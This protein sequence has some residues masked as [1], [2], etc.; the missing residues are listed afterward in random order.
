MKHCLHYFSLLLGG[1][2]LLTTGRLHAQC[3]PGNPC[4]DAQL[5][6][7]SGSVLANLPYSP[8]GANTSQRMRIRK[9]NLVARL[10]LEK[11]GV[12]PLVKQDW[13]ATLN[14]K[15]T[16]KR[17]NG[18]VLRVRDLA[19]KA[20]PGKPEVLGEVDVTDIEGLIGSVEVKLMGYTVSG[21]HAQLARQHVRCILAWAPE[22]GYDVQTPQNQALAVLDP[23]VFPIT[24]VQNASEVCQVRFAWEMPANQHV[25][26]FEVE[27]LKAEPKIQSG[28][29]VL[30]WTKANKLVLET[31]S[32]LLETVNGGTAN[33]K[34]Y[35]FIYLLAEGTGYYAWRVR[36]LGDY[37]ERGL[38]NA[39]NY[40]EWNLNASVIANHGYAWKPGGMDLQGVNP[41]NM[42]LLPNGNAVTGS[43]FYYQQFDAQ[44]NFI[45]GRIFSEGSRMAETMTYANGLSQAQQTQTRSY[46]QH[47][48]LGTQ[49]VLDFSGRPALQSMVAPMGTD[50]LQYRSDFFRKQGNLPYKAEDF[51]ANG[52]VYPGATIVDATKGPGFYYSDA[53]STNAYPLGDLVPDANGFPYTRTLFYPDATG[54]VY[55]QSAPGEV[56]RLKIGGH[57]VTT[58]YGAVTQGELDIVFGNEAPVD[59]TVYKVVSLDPNTVSS[60]TYMAKNGTVLATCLS[61]NGSLSN[62]EDVGN[63]NKPGI[64]TLHY[65]LSGGSRTVGDESVHQQTTIIVE[66]AGT[67]APFYYE[68]TPQVFGI[69]CADDI[70]YTCDYRVEFEIVLTQDPDLHARFYFDIPPVRLAQCQATQSAL[71]LGSNALPY[72]QI[73]FDPANTL[74]PQGLIDI[75]AGK[76][77]FPEAGTYL[78]TKTIYANNPTGVGNSR[79][80]DAYLDSLR[81]MREGWTADTNCCGPIVVDTS[82]WDCSATEPWCDST[83]AKRADSLMHW[84]ELEQRADYKLHLTNAGLNLTGNSYIGNNYMQVLLNYMIV[85]KGL[86]CSDVWGCFQVMGGQLEQNIAGFDANGPPLNTQSGGLPNTTGNPA[87]P[88]YDPD[89]DFMKEVIACTG[90]NDPCRQYTEVMLYRGSA[91]SN[92]P[93]NVLALSIPAAN[94]QGTTDEMHHL[95]CVMGY[96]TFNA[97]TITTPYTLHYPN[98]GLSDAAA[99][100]GICECVQTPLNSGGGSAV[101][102]DSIQAGIVNACETGCENHRGAFAQAIDNWVIDYN[103]AR[104]AVSM[105]DTHWVNIDSIMGLDRECVI[106][107]MVAQCKQQCQM[108]K[109]NSIDPDSMSQGPSFSQAY[110]DSILS[111]AFQA[112]L[113]QERLEFEQAMTWNAAF[114]PV[115]DPLGSGG[116]YAD[117]GSLDVVEDE[118]LSFLERAM[119]EVLAH[120]SADANVTAASNLGIYY[121][122]GSTAN[123]ALA[124]RY[125]DFVVPM[126]GGQQ[127]SFKQMTAVVGLY[128]DTATKRMKELDVVLFCNFAVDTTGSLDVLSGTPFAHW[129]YQ[130]ACGSC[131]GQVQQPTAAD[132]YLNHHPEAIGSCLR[133]DPFTLAVGLRSSEIVQ[134]RFD[135]QGVLHAALAGTACPAVVDADGICPSASKA[136]FSL[137][138]AAGGAANQALRLEIQSQQDYYDLF[139][140]PVTWQGDAIATASAIVAAINGSPSLPPFKAS[141]EDGTGAATAMV[142]IEVRPSYTGEV[143]ALRLGAMGTLGVQVNAL[144][145][146]CGGALDSLLKPTSCREVPNTNGRECPY[147][148]FKVD[149]QAS[150]YP[151]TSQG[152]NH[153][154]L[155]MIAWVDDAATSIIRTRLPER[156][157]YSPQ[158]GFQLYADYDTLDFQIG[159]AEFRCLV[160]F[161]YKDTQ[162]GEC[163]TDGGTTWHPCDTITS[164]PN[165]LYRKVVSYGNIHYFWFRVLKCPERSAQELVALNLSRLT[166]NQSLWPN[167][168]N[169]GNLPQGF[170]A[171]DDL[172]DLV[173]EPNGR[174]K[175]TS[176]NDNSPSY[177][178]HGLTHDLQLN[179]LFVSSGGVFRDNVTQVATS[180]NPC[181]PR[182]EECE[183]CMR[184]SK[185][186]MPDAFSDPVDYDP[187]TCE[188]ALQEYI[189][190]TVAGILDSCLTARLEEMK[191]RYYA[192][193]L[194]RIVDKCTIDID[195]TYHHY[196]LYYRDRANNLVATVPPEGVDFLNLASLNYNVTNPPVYPNHLLQTTYKYNSIQQVVEQNS[197]D[198]GTSR[199]WYNAAG[200]LVLSQDAQ[201]ALEGKHA[202]S[203]YDHLGRIVES[204]VLIGFVPTFAPNQP[205]IITE[206]WD[207]PS[208][209]NNL[210]LL[211]RQEVVHTQYTLPDPSITYLGQPQTHTRNRITHVWK[212]ENNT[213][214]VH[215]STWYSYDEHGSVRW[216]IQE[217][218]SLGRKQMRY[219][220]DLVSGNVNKVYYQEG[221]VEQFIHRYEYDADNRIVAVF[222]STDDK[223]W[224]RDAK[225]E[226][227]LHGPLA[228]KELGEDLV[229]GMDYV[230]TIEGYLKS[231]NQ[232]ELD[233]LKDPGR[234]GVMQYGTVKDE[235]AMELGYYAGDYGRTGSHI[236]Q[237]NAAV[238][239]YNGAGGMTPAVNDLYNG[240]ISYWMSN[241]R[242]G[243]VAATDINPVGLQMRTFRY[244]KLNRLRFANW[245][246]YENGTWQ[247]GDGT[248]NEAFTYDGNGNIKTLLRNGFVGT[249]STLDMDQLTYHYNYNPQGRLLD[250]RLYH[251]RDAVANSP[252]TDDLEDQ[253]APNTTNFTTSNNYRYDAEG[254]L[255]ADLSEGIQQIK[256][257]AAN[258]VREV[259]KTN[260]EHIY[261]VYDALGNRII[262]THVHE[263]S[264][265]PK[266][267]LEST[268]YVRDASGNPMG[269]YSLAYK[270]LVDSSYWKL[271]E[272]PIY[273]SERIGEYKP[274]LVLAA[275]KGFLGDF[276]E[277]TDV[278][279]DLMRMWLLP[280]NPNVVEMNLAADGTLGFV[281]LANSQGAMPKA[282]SAVQ[283]G[284]NGA[285]LFGAMVTDE[286]QPQLLLIGKDKNPMAGVGNITIVCGKGINMEPVIIPVPGV[287]D[288]YY[289]VYHAG[290]GFT[291]IKALEVDMAGNGGNGIVV[292][293]AGPIAMG[294]TFGHKLLPFTYTDGNS[295]LL[296]NSKSADGKSLLLQRIDVTAAG[297]SAPTLLA[298]V[299]MPYGNLVSA[300]NDLGLAADGKWLAL[301]LHMGPAPL[302]VTGTAFL[303]VMIW[304][305]DAASLLLDHPKTY[306]MQTGKVRRVEFSPSGDYLF[307]VK[308]VMGS[309]RLERLRL[310]DGAA[311]LAG[312]GNVNMNIQRITNGKMV[313]HYGLGTVLRRM[314]DPETNGTTFSGTLFVPSA[315][316]KTGE[317]P[318]AVYPVD[319]PMQDVAYRVK[320]ADH[321][322]IASTSGAPNA[323]GMNTLLIPT[324]GSPVATNPIAANAGLSRCIS[325]G[326]DAHDS[327]DFRHVAP[328]GWTNLN[329]VFRP[330]LTLMQNGMGL[331]G[332]PDLPS[333]AVELPGGEKG[334]YVFT[335]AVG[336]LKVHRVALSNGELAVV[337][338]NQNV[339]L[340]AGG[341][342]Q[343]DVANP[344][345]A[346]AGYNDHATG[347][348]SFLFVATKYNGAV[349]VYSFRLSPDRIGAGQFVKQYGNPNAANPGLL[350]GE[351]QVAPS[352]QELS[353]SMSVPGAGSQ[354]I[355][356]RLERFTVDPRLAAGL[357]YAGQVEVAAEAVGNGANWPMQQILSHDYSPEGKY[358]YFLQKGWAN[359]GCWIPTP[360]LWLKRVNLQTNAV[361]DITH[362]AYQEA[363]GT[364]RRG[365]DG[366]LYLNYQEKNPGNNYVP[367]LYGYGQLDHVAP[368]VVKASRS[369]VNLLGG[370]NRYGLPLQ[371]WRRYGEVAPAAAYAEREVGARVYELNDHLGNVR[372]TVGDEREHLVLGNG[373]IGFAKAGVLSFEDYFAF[374][375]QLPGRN[376]YIV[377][378]RFGFNGQESDDEVSGIRESYTFSFR[379]YDP[380]TMRFKSIDPLFQKYPWNSP[381][382]FAE[383]SPIRYI[384]FEGLEKADPKE[385][386]LAET[387]IECN[388]SNGGQSSY[389]PDITRE[390]F[391]NQLKNLVCNPESADLT[392]WFCGP[393]AITYTFLNYNP[394]AFTTAA[395]ELYDHGE[396]NIPGGGKITAV[397]HGNMSGSN[398]NAAF[399]LVAASLRA[400]QSGG[401]LDP[402]TPGATTPLAFRK[403]AN[404][405]GLRVERGG[406]WLPKNIKTMNNAAN[407]GKFSILLENYRVSHGAKY[408]GIFTYIG[409][410]YITMTT[411][412]SVHGKNLDFRWWDHRSSHKNDPL[413]KYE[414]TEV[415]FRQGVK[416]W[417]ILAK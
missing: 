36:P 19:L 22:I 244:D 267:T 194:D 41:G 226:Y 87:G 69:A 251:L 215:N 318:Q 210:P 296:V 89:F 81:V 80:L 367:Y 103:A 220:Y 189:E 242:S 21:V 127:P 124:Y 347:G 369:Q 415:N 386:E 94:G 294:S 169:P 134:F 269:I 146:G 118:L 290:A 186:R 63:E 44:K 380:R 316:I 196:T 60:V 70:C 23:L 277:A 245:R 331:Q 343:Y 231:I 62:L 112:L 222:T 211:Q 175:F 100:A 248:Y 302:Q 162:R 148:Y 257:N 376:S 88:Q 46:S 216:L 191:A 199:F 280:G 161:G 295:R 328:S 115:K 397:Q 241:I 382:A 312:S 409:V 410:H 84:V 37:H 26:A 34:R 14:L 355:H 193:C 289:V 101:N 159:D 51:D 404:S 333:I 253:G 379:E 105:A 282:H 55:K 322:W 195:V 270:P 372:V 77:K 160:G 209:P 261:F 335:F 416:G 39:L 307:V 396:V 27:L 12:Y 313:Y 400:S 348:G 106:D 11:N 176:Q 351:M 398:P 324:V 49:S 113:A 417:W 92:V 228:R 321:N 152:I 299:P 149:P 144:P 258:K 350:L 5:S 301:G 25:P 67:Q 342:L 317:F 385:F 306:S 153:A 166:A 65:S 181:G 405:L 378:N 223:I 93:P 141:N 368:V 24:C 225:Y 218:P 401:T 122:G 259:V 172:F 263:P 236:G 276:T 327:L 201:Q 234:D 271:D 413:N 97:Q 131:Q 323:S 391:G 373:Q 278:A 311:L 297:F 4:L 198:G 119:D 99:A 326:E 303:D 352:G 85:T 114:A 357:A 117:F 143:M 79:W 203:R 304:G 411:S 407:E 136:T 95:A 30:D 20:V 121:R 287:A 59:T 365:A 151:A 83:L 384:E 38:S 73:Q 177:G 116:G 57:N 300:E 358:V 207:E 356:H 182:K 86:N 363:K 341:F 354:P 47:Q 17:G 174:L 394:I 370:L 154:I 61:H 252:Y 288:H 240:N 213:G 266:Q 50:Q 309:A 170:S 91:P 402:D 111:P 212:D 325:I 2:L 138:V 155:D 353:I 246:K 393:T 232:V 339:G 171:I 163:S 68:I 340:A 298:V 237:A 132:L 109:T 197:P 329:L 361:Q 52:T 72:T 40:G 178:S 310:A 319:G 334:Y 359:P 383:N 408:G 224:E 274:D 8:I 145:Q 98:W 66:Q 362:Y 330:D 375:A 255:V 125:Q 349:S 185:A 247:V 135:D 204:G 102:M 13:A 56:M 320:T 406:F 227:Y 7:T 110:A 129:S 9:L 221:T 142:T 1:L 3:P 336:R 128:Y 35:Q 188:D 64:Q 173:L 71:V 184:W 90:M 332:E 164:N 18:T 239:P 28:A 283:T 235:F 123:L 233:S 279:P 214:D 219:D 305:I 76:L 140:P 286:A 346:I 190:N 381:Y 126:G 187:Y 256:W 275:D 48:V 388:I 315:G 192:A 96:Y 264:Q 345:V 392:E 156:T 208:F 42:R 238:Y 412:I 366:R 139:A 104:G 371:A 249:G 308:E 33:R 43:I 229:Q 230:Y 147:G 108:E 338:S 262:K 395:F 82:G 6:V 390:E 291:A 360:A 243:Q 403:M 157:F 165:I 268:F 167:F 180:T 281:T 260:N 137:T 130:P 205:M 31:G 45:Y 74:P 250:N 314:N 284:E 377:Q 285:F 10:D 150:G 53:N 179:P 78:I 414:G 58:F 272:M 32:P 183:V 374:G 399:Q 293:N 364:V 54:R 273:G 29:P 344:Q 168:R 254:N 75:Q 107:Q 15:C 202:Y 158:L 200:Q 120:P 387:N 337:S 389:F 206:I 16:F 265:G 133:L 292:G 217:L